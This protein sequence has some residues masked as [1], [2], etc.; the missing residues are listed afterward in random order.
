MKIF[1]QYIIIWMGMMSI[2]GVCETSDHVP[3]Y[4]FDVVTYLCA[5]N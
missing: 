2:T 5:K 4:F 3:N 1:H